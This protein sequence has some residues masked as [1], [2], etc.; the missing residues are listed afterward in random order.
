[1]SKNQFYIV[2]YNDLY[3]N[4]DDTKIEVLVKN[5][6]AFKKWLKQW[7]KERKG[8]ALMEGEEEFDL[9]PIKLFEPK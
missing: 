3:G 8:Y 7:N 6:T 2:Q 4:G 1:M 9:I 5:K